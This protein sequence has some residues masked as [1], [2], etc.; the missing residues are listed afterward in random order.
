MSSNL[1]TTTLD[2]RGLQCPAPI[3]KTAQ[4]A[5]ALAKSG[6]MLK[7]I[8]DDDAFPLDIKSWCR[9]SKFTLLE[10]GQSA[11]GA[12]MALIRFAAPDATQRANKGAAKA[13]AIEAA[14]TVEA[15]RERIDCLGQSCPEPILTLAKAA[16]RFA[17]GTEVEVV[18]DDPAFPLDV[19][20]WCRSAGAEL[21]DMKDDEAPYRVLLRMGTG[22]PRKRSLRPPKVEPPQ[23]IEPPQVIEVPEDAVTLRPPARREERPL[24]VDLSSYAPSER[25]TALMHAIRTGGV[26]SQV[27]VV[28]PDTQFNQELL[29]WCAREGHT[30]RSLN[31]NGPVEA[32]LELAPG[33][34]FDGPMVTTPTAEWVPAG[35]P[36]ALAPTAENNRCSLLV[37]HNDH[38]SLLAAMLIATGAAAS[39][40]EVSV[41][42][43]FWGLNLLRGDRPNLE[44]KKEKTS[45]VQRMF[46]WMMPR[47]TQK[48]KLGQMN[49]GG[50][51]KGMLDKIMKDQKLMLLPDLVD[52]AQ[53]QGVRFIA[54]TM[55]MSVM[56]ITKRDLHPY[57]TLE[58]G[59]V[60]AFIAEARS[61]S[62][63]LVF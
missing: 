44:E 6:G 2:C 13:P 1:P 50:A 56:G 30:P 10:M 60:A 49:F 26:P 54:C 37:L 22:K 27:L 62:M 23:G 42:F 48:Q 51:G 32:L 63:Q 28:A 52:S 17:P 20:S 12:H 38:E 31:G 33:A 29:Q 39:G 40:M 7:V 19:A 59:G 25:M 21:V 36:M 35:Q 9:S 47:G 46:K 16:R 3:L 18:A 58:Y 11:D 5:K 57:E 45:F 14:E 55:S 41:F 61:A 43:T 8:A 53:D 24:R 34:R 15:P 4:A